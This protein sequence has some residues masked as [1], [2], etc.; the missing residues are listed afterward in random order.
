M[1]KILSLLEE[2]GS[3]K[4]TELMQ[5]SDASS[6]RYERDLNTLDENGK[7]LKVHGGAILREQFFIHR[8]MMCHFE[9]TCIVMRR[10]L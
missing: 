5:L 2:Q 1:E 6:Q 7:L 10:Q 8:M 9:E 4:V 3:V